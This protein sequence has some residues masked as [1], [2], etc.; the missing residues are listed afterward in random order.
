MIRL[1]SLRSYHPAEQR[2]PMMKQRSKTNE[3]NEAEPELQRFGSS[4]EEKW[5][6]RETNEIR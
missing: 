2:D 6:E 5:K 3:K 4:R 1:D